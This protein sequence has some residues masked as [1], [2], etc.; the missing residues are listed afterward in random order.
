[1]AAKSLAL[2]GNIREREGESQRGYQASSW[3]GAVSLPGPRRYHAV[4]ASLPI[5]A[6]GS[7]YYSSFEKS[8]RREYTWDSYKREKKREDKAALLTAHFDSCK[9]AGYIDSLL[10]LFIFS[11]SF[12]VR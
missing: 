7:S 4:L 11:L 8:A 12:E 2:G 10:I 6:R 1:M 9:F 3:S 5:V